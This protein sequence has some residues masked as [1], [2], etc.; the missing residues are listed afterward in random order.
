MRRCRSLYMRSLIVLIACWTA[1][2]A[3][4]PT[5]IGVVLV[6]RTAASEPLRI[7]RVFAD[8]GADK[9]GVQSNCLLISINGTNAVNMPLANASNFIRGPSGSVVVIRVADVARKATNEFR[10]I[11]RPIKLPEFE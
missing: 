3:N 4:I 8:T 1:S 9:A 11:R 2:G 6:N 10:I 5:G 7:T